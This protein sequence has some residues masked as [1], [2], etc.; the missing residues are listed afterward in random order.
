[1]N[2]FDEKM[3]EYNSALTDG[4]IMSLELLLRVMVI[5]KVTE[6]Y[7]VEELVGMLLKSAKGDQY[8]AEQKADNLTGQIPNV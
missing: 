5:N 2:Q 4:R 6:I 3:K 7:E 8:E 1:M